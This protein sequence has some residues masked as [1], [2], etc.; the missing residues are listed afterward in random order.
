MVSNPL[1]HDRIKHIDLD[2]HFIEEN[3]KL[4]IDLPY[5]SYISFQDNL[6]GLITKEM[7]N[8]YFEKIVFKLRMINVHSPN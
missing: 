3:E 5:A 6:A 8:N 7:N 4:N 2:K 1:Q